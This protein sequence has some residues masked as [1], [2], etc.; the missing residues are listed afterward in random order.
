MIYFPKY[1]SR[2]AI[3]WYFVSLV[4]VSLVF[5]TNLMPAY[6][7]LFGAVS[8][9][10]FFAGSSELTRRWAPLRSKTFEKKLFA[11]AFSIRLFYVIFI[12]LLNYSLYGTFHESE[13]ADIGWYMESGQ[14]IAD[15]IRHGKWNFISL[16]SSWGIR[17][18]DMGYNIYLAFVYLICG[19]W[20][21]VIVPLILKAFW[22]SLTCLYMYRI[23]T[24]HFGE[25]VGRMTGVFCMLQFN[26][27]WWCG[28][29]MKETEMVF[30]LVAAM[31]AFDKGMLGKKLNIKTLVLALLLVVPVFYFRSVLGIALIASIVLVILLSGNKQV[32]STKKILAGLVFAVVAF[33]LVRGSVF[34][35]PESIIQENMERE[36]QDVNMEWRAEREGG[37]TL[38]VHASTAVF[39]PLIFIL[40]FPSMTYTQQ[41]Q[42]MLMQVN[43][44]NYVK[45]VM[46]FFCMLA[47]ILMLFNGK[48][49]EHIIPLTVLL[50][51][52]LSLAVSEF[53]QSGRFHLPA[54]PL[55][56]MFAAYGITLMTPKRKSWFVAFLVL[57]FL[58]CIGWNWFKL[59]GRGLV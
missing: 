45:N 12:Y 16:Y 38:A 40:P 1:F 15:M 43:G 34:P 42:E 36:E 5:F 39:A 53:A 13:G 57:E 48:W 33:V 46:A 52:L 28:S 44:G 54:I 30:I 59:A 14:Y 58:F 4:A 27:I 51:Y 29:M 50:V 3:I 35:H 22:G 2:Q 31:N 18:D 26:L 6:L 23:A 24:R 49:R 47:V 11:G 10:A 7:Y 9:V 55:E 41:D 32:S 20:S 8:V 56:M 37:N 21:D 19:S 25:G 17:Y